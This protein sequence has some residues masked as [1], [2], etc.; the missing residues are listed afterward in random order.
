MVDVATVHELADALAAFGDALQR[1]QQR[2]KLA[3]VP[4]ARV[5]LQGSP[6]R[7]VLH[8]ALPRDIVSVGGDEREGIL[9]IALVFGQVKTDP[10]D[11][12]PDGVVPRQIPLHAP[13]ALADFGR[14][15]GTDVE[16]RDCSGTRSDNERVQVHPEAQG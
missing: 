8:P 1:R 11:D 15:R 6:Q 16:R 12:V 13:L 7:Q 14:E 9:P 5:L 3:L 10:T 2:E 4:G